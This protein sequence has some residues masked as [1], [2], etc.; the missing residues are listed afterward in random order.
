M[1][2]ISTKNYKTRHNWVGKVNRMTGKKIKS[3]EYFMSLAI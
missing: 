3:I 2:Q 1:Q